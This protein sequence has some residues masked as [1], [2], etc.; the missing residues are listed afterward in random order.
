[1]VL[2]FRNV[3]EDKLMDWAFL[4]ERRNPSLVARAVIAETK[5]LSGPEDLKHDKNGNIYWVEHEELFG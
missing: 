2:F 5:N 1:M 4:T 3:P